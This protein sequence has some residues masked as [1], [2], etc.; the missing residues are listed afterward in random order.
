MIYKSQ[1]SG[2]CVFV[3]C[4]CVC[5]GG[6]GEVGERKACVNTPVIF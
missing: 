4:V 3:W 2:V 1:D 5:E 6:G